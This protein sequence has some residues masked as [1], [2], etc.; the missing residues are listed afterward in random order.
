MK[1]KKSEYG[2]LK[3][4]PQ[5]HTDPLSSTQPPQFHTK[6]PSFPPPSVPHPKPISSDPPQFHTKNPSVQHTPS[7]RLYR[8]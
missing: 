7:V 8:A 3:S 5:F 6:N 2:Y 4:T 1:L